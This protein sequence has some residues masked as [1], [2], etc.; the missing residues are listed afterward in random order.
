MKKTAICL[1]ISCLLT[2]NAFA[3]SNQNN[4]KQEDILS[5]VLSQLLEE[6]EGNTVKEQKTKKSE[7]IKPQNEIKNDLDLELNKDKERVLISKT[8]L[9]ETENKSDKLLN[10][11]IVINDI[12]SNEK[13]INVSQNQDNMFLLNVPIKTIIRANID[14]VIPPFRNKLSY[15]E[16]KLVSENPFNYSEDVT[17]CYLTIE[18]S[19]FWRRFKSST[20][21][22]DKKLTIESNNSSKLTYKSSLN[23]DS[24]VNVY[25]TTFTTDN[26]HIKEI[27]CE[28]SEK[29]L[30]LT[31]KDLNKATGNL[32]KFEYSPMID[33]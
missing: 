17:Y 10:E 15:S 20:Y 21:D 26:K 14:I 28:T 33:I 11:N 22:Q 9:L 16:G 31:I 13:E 12:N 27:V 7:E 3:D 4:K 1:I 32:F 6:G 30:P 29:E 5:S 8:D 25:E 18:E 23:K 19:G 24:I 2:G